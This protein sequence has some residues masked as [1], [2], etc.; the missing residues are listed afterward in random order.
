MSRQYKTATKTV[1]TRSNLKTGNE[2]KTTQ[3]TTMYNSRS[4]KNISKGESLL[5]MT[6]KE[7]NDCVNNPKDK[8]NY[9]KNKR[10]ELPFETTLTSTAHLNVEE[11]EYNNEQINQLIEDIQN[12]YGGSIDI[13]EELRMFRESRGRSGYKT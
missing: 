7:T 10:F 2:I 13:E 8:V 4:H 3:K 5:N 11:E 12:R 6:F 1:T 9:R